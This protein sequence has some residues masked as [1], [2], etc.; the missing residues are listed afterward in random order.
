MSL[1]RQPRPEHEAGSATS[2][3]RPGNVRDRGALAGAPAVPLK[4]FLF[5]C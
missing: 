4:R 3:A 5:G 2:V 1:V